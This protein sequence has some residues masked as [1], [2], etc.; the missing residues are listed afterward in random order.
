MKKVLSI[1]TAISFLFVLSAV[2]FAQEGSARTPGIRN[3]Q[4]NQQ[5]RD[6]ERSKADTDKSA[7]LSYF[8]LLKDEAALRFQRFDLFLARELFFQR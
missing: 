4:I 8:R 2:G 1:L 6:A 5:K 3:R 7:A